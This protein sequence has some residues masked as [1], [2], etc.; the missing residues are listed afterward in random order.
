MKTKLISLLLFFFLISAIPQEK[1]V[2]IV[3]S[4]IRDKYHLST[5]EWAK[6]IWKENLI[7]FKSIEAA[8]SAGYKP[9]KVC[10]PD[11]NYGN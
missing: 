7:V 4:K 11:K 1:E 2:K 10:K 3:G 5:C 8:D 6:K 9:C